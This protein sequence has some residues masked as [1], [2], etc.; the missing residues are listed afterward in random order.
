MTEIEAKKIGSKQGLFS[1]G[2]GLLIAQLIMTWFSSDNGIVKGFFW[3]K[4]FS[5]NLN[6]VIGTI[7]ML[8][9]GHLFGQLA[10]KAILIKKT[11]SSCYFRS[12]NYNPTW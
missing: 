1:V 9:S 10:G 6:I 8:L 7:I 4:T 3:F 11:Q 2:I 5:Y 12:L